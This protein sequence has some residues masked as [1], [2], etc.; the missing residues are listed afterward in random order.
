[1]VLRKISLYSERKSNSCLQSLTILTRWL[2]LEFLR[3]EWLR[4][5]DVE[6]LET[7]SDTT[8]QCSLHV[9]WGS[10]QI[11]RP[12]IIY[13]KGHKTGRNRV[14]N[15]QSIEQFL[16]TVW[17]SLFHQSE[18]C[19]G[20]LSAVASETMSPGADM[21]LETLLSTDDQPSS[22]LWHEY[23][24]RSRDQNTPPTDQSHGP[25]SLILQIYTSWVLL[26]S[27][28]SWVLPD[29]SDISTACAPP[30]KVTRDGESPSP[31][32]S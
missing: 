14:Y 24:D 2:Y 1:M 22:W 8:L 18:L 23:T 10:V 11:L 20:L 28:Q 3:R 32:S 21:L 4:L 7:S 17:Q 9:S 26:S 29:K 5:D 27:N 13:W 15:G 16:S 12:S 25:G 19:H 30:M 31:W 6:H